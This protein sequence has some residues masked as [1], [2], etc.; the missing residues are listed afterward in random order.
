ML[1]SVT[2]SRSRCS[3]DQ[4][5]VLLGRPAGGGLL[6][7]SPGVLLGPLAVGQVAGD[8]REAEQAPRLVLQGRDDDVGPEQRAVLADPP[9]LVLEAALGR[10]DLQFVGGPAPVERLLRV[11]RE[12]CW[13]MISS[14]V[15]PLIR[16]APAFQVATWP[17]GSSMKMA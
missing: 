6:G 15:Y 1:A 9:A 17:C 11:E 14:A 16:S 4:P 5:G 8:L 2:C 10:G 13:P 3:L 7:E 12:K